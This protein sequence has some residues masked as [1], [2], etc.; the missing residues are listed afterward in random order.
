MIMLAATI[1]SCSNDDDHNS[2]APVFVANP[3]N[4]SEAPELIVGADF[5]EHAVIVDNTN[6][7]DSEVDAPGCGGYSGGDLWYKVVV[8]ASGNLTIETDLDDNAEGMVYDTVL[9]VYGGNCDSLT[10]LGCQDDIGNGNY[11]SKLTLTDFTPGE[12]LYVRAYVYNND[13]LG[14]FK[15]SAYDSN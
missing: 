13:V 3:D 1:L 2:A 5:S 8:P 9:A 6:A 10:E 12:I 14:T 4:C 7:T 15:L 11:F